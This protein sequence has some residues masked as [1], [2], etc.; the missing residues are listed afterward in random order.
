MGEGFQAV[1]EKYE[2]QRESERKELARYLSEQIGQSALKNKL[3]IVKGAR[4]GRGLPDY[5]SGKRIFP[6]DLKNWKWVELKSEDARFDCL[7]SLNMMER[8]PH[9]ANIHCLYDR[10]GIQISYNIGHLHYKTDIYTDIELPL[11]NMDRERITGVV[12]AQFNLFCE[13]KKGDKAL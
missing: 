4:A 8:D 6:Y 11:K 9:T 12:I 13:L 3:K 2:Q 1:K 5:T 7:I 10:I